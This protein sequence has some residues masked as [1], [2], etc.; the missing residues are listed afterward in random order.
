MVYETQYMIRRKRNNAAVLLTGA[1][2]YKLSKLRGPEVY[3]SMLVCLYI[4]FIVVHAELF[5]VEL[6]HTEVLNYCPAV[7]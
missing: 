3:A 1:L 2:L 5:E 6:E 7:L 4:Y